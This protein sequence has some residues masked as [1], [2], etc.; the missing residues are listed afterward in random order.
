LFLEQRV[1]ETR[2]HLTDAEETLKTYQEEH[3]TIGL[4]EENR[5]TLLAGA[6]LEAYVMM[7][8]VQRDI[9]SKKLGR[10]HPTLQ[11]M[12]IELDIARNRLTELPEVGLA[13]VRLFREVEMQTRIL[14][15]L[16]AQYEQ[17]KIQEVRDTPTIQII[18]HAVPPQ[19][20]YYP[21]RMYIVAGACLSSLLFSLFLTIH[22]ESMRQ[23][24][25]AGTARGKQIDQILTELKSMKLWGRK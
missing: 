12:E 17:A 21:K 24:R 18:D 4:S 9:L 20:K 23:E 22:L 1:F 3:A 19:Q 13:L 8:E 5:A 10:S 7:M 6:E 14:A 2:R 16:L 25:S 11:R 15:F